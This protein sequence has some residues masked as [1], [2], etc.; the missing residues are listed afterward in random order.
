[1]VLKFQAFTEEANLKVLETI[2]LGKVSRESAGNLTHFESQNQER[3]RS[4]NTTPSY[5]K[6]EEGSLEQIEACEGRF[7]GEA[8]EGEGAA[9]KYGTI[10]VPKTRKSDLSGEQEVEER[11]GQDAWRRF[12]DDVQ[13]EVGKLKEAG[14]LGLRSQEDEGRKE[15]KGIVLLSQGE[16]KSRVHWQQSQQR[17]GE[18][19]T[20]NDFVLN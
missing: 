7:E 10:C 14:F 2:E 17:P 8:Y 16:A 6:E 5:Q 13:G 18:S 12:Q 4:Q 9:V 15:E 19:G 1:M 20:Q 3:W 11:R